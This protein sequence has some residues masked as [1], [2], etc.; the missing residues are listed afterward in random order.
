MGRFVAKPDARRSLREFVKGGPSFVASVTDTTFIG[1][2]GG[3]LQ[4]FATKDKRGEVFVHDPGAG[5]FAIIADSRDAFA[6]MDALVD[7]WDRYADP[8]GVDIEELT[9]ADKAEPAFRDF[10]RRALALLPHVS[11]VTGSDYDETLRALAG[12]SSRVRAR[13][14]AESRY[15]AMKWLMLLFIDRDNR[16]A[17]L[18]DGRNRRASR[19]PLDSLWRA[20]LYAPDA[21]LFRSFTKSPDALVRLTAQRMSRIVAKHEGTALDRVALIA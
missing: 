20:F 1:K 14:D 3:G 19:D 4:F 17:R 2:D 18:E 5:Q 9:R 15:R 13:S 11:L 16:A 21:L 7:L 6:R 10:R 12:K 8:R